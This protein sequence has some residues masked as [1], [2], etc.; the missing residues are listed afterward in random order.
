MDTRPFRLSEEWRVAQC[1][2]ECHRP[3]NQSLD[4]VIATQVVRTSG[5]RRPGDNCMVQPDRREC[6]DHRQHSRRAPWWRR[7][8]LVD[9]ARCRG[10]DGGPHHDVDSRQSLTDL[11]QQRDQC[12][13]ESPENDV[14]FAVA[15]ST[16][17]DAPI[18]ERGDPEKPGAPVPRRW[19]EMFGG[20]KVSAEGSGRL[21]LAK[22]LTDEANPL[23]YRVIV[24]RIWLQHFGAG[25][26]ATP[27]DFGTRG[28]APT[29][30]EMLDWLAREFITHEGASSRCT[31][32]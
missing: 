9:E 1:L 8:R 7:R 4:G 25:L 17:V 23:T 5:S 10:F 22:W 15:E 20:G 26:V 6:E 3:A 14:A 27:N 32:C 29:H 31:G 13:R 19:L 11:R 21:E 18:Q 24:N 30:P 28:A 16:P 2:C 12:E